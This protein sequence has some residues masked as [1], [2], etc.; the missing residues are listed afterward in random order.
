MNIDRAAFL[1][2]IQTYTETLD[3]STIEAVIFWCEKHGFEPEYVA[4]LIKKNR[5]LKSTV[6]AEAKKLNLIK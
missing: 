1:A 2:D 4:N 3:M 5:A 6:K